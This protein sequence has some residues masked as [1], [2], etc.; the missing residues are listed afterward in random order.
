MNEENKPASQPQNITAQN[1]A[2]EMLPDDLK[3]QFV[4]Q[5]NSQNPVSPGAP[6]SSTSS[7]A[8]FNAQGN[9]VGGPPTA[10][11]LDPNL[12]QKPIRT[13]ES[14][15]AEA[16]AKKQGSVASISIAENKKRDEE[17]RRAEMAAKGQ[18]Q[19]P[20]Q[21]SRFAP[22]AVSPTRETA[23]PGASISIPPEMPQDMKDMRAGI[24]ATIREAQ[25]KQA[26]PTPSAQQQAS[27]LAAMQVE[28]QA[29]KA[30]QVP[31]AEA[32]PTYAVNVPQT[33]QTPRRSILKPFLLTVFSI[34]LIGGGL[35]AGYYIYMKNV[36]E[37]PVTVAP[38]PIVVAGLIPRDTL[39]MVSVTTE[40]GNP[41]I[42]KIYSEVNKNPVGS[43]K[44]LEVRLYEKKGEA[45]QVVTGSDF[46]QK[47]N[48]S[49]PN[50]IVRSLTDRW[51]FGVYGEET[52]QKTTF[53]ALT[54]DFFQNAFAG[55]LSWE[56]NGMAD[57]LAL[58][59][60]F[61]D[62]ARK[63]ELN[64]T[65]TISSYFTIRGQYTDKVLRNRDI[66]EFRNPQGELLF[67]YSFINKE[68][69]LLTTTESAFVALVDRIE[70]DAYVR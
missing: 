60:N 58:L 7:P 61:K 57:D 14:D 34:V 21:Q 2:Q 24:T 55:M 50:V 42:S 26:A 46:I 59:L 15:L 63:D 52:G 35:Y 32:A 65:T 67:L 47:L 25:P 68:T 5:K 66:R 38:A 11:K 20:A 51:M 62:R 40:M 3:K 45:S 37:K 28:P 30:P 56:N 13:Y 36:S 1:I 48:T 53:V 23:I 9:M 22:R 29:R 10:E 49:I 43:G 16:L 69:L 39:A 27:V 44:S 18:P 54:T 41:L 17:S 19:T 64:S 31:Y 33:E 6:A 70:K 4:L 12:I 8:T